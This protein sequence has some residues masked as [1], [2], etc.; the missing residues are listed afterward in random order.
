LIPTVDVDILEAALIEGRRPA[1]VLRLVVH[2]CG[3]VKARQD[4][5][6][7][8][9]PRQEPPEAE[10]EPPTGEVLR[11]VTP[12]HHAR[13]GREVAYQGDGAHPGERLFAIIRINDEYFPQEPVTAQPDGTFDGTVIV[14]RPWN[15]CGKSF[16]LRIFGQVRQT[17]AVGVPVGAWPSSLSA[18]LPVQLVRAEECGPD[19]R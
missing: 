11:L 1:A 18:S 14:G 16:E 6:A 9:T 8:V 15:D 17:L 5:Q 13:V 2:G 12:H 3:S 7:A 19:G 4:I 10:A